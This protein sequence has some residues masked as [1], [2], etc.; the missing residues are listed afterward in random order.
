MNGA[1]ARRQEREFALAPPVADKAS[2]NEWQSFA[3]YEP[4]FRRYAMRFELFVIGLTRL[5]RS[6]I[7]YAEEPVFE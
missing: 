1:P 2:V 4:D 5:N 6:D 7:L 3:E